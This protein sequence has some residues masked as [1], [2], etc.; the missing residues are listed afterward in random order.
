MKW[1]NKEMSKTRKRIMLVVVLLFI[2][3]SL[4]IVSFSEDFTTNES[5]AEST[6]LNQEKMDDE[7]IES[8]TEV[9]DFNESNNDEYIEISS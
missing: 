2:I 8:T 4:V 3:N 5:F 6:T 9:Y 7:I 1:R